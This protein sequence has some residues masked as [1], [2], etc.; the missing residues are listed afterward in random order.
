MSV[1]RGV[2]LEVR[3][4]LVGDVLRLYHL[5]VRNQT[6]VF[7]L[8]SKHRYF[9]SHFVGHPQ[10]SYKASAMMIFMV[11]Q[12][13][14]PITLSMLLL[15]LKISSLVKPQLRT[16]QVSNALASTGWH[17]CEG[18]LQYKYRKHLK[19]YFCNFKLK[20]FSLYH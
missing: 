9:L 1:C 15:R 17:R 2:H 19:W 8:S 20:H 6:Q 14:F 7:K 11:T 4:Q 10:F 5:G 12:A 18:S 16:I 3:G 13:H